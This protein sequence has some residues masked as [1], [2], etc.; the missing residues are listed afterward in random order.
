M[1]LISKKSFVKNILPWLMCSLA[2]VFYCYEY[3]QR[4]STSVL[5]T[6]IME[7]YQINIQ[8]FG[9]L[10]ASYYWAYTPMQVLVGTLMD[11][12]GVRRLMTMAIF[13]CA[14]GAFFFG[15]HDS[16]AIAMLSRFT[17]GFG[18]AFA[19]VGVLKLASDWLPYRY[20]SL[21]SGITTML[22]MLGA[23]SGEIL[24]EDLIQKIG[25]RPT[26]LSSALFAALLTVCAWFIIKDHPR[27]TYKVKK[28]K[29]ASSFSLELR[30]LTQDISSVFMQKQ[31]L[32][33]AT[34]G[35]CLFM[36]TTLFA[37][38]WGVDY[39][40]NVKSV[41]IIQAATITSSIFVGWAIGA[42]IMGLL[43]ERIKS[44]RYL[45]MAGS[46]IA[47][48]LVS[49]ALYDHSISLNQ[50]RVLFFFVGFASSTQVLVFAVAHDLVN[51]KLIG[52]GVA[53]TNM[54][55][56]IGGLIQPIIG[57][58]LIWFTPLSY[59]ATVTTIH[60]P[61]SSYEKALLVLPI[62]FILSA[63][64]STCFLKE[65]YRAT[66]RKMKKSHASKPIISH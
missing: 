30:S 41:S 18:S 36:P 17:I 23:I 4:V 32:I 3:F 52:T 44:R 6:E 45:M 13:L 51:P 5:Q 1:S 31:F 39:L 43:T 63:I 16:I 38:Q 27:S 56:N 28:K 2:A 66:D 24:L 61:Q 19:F 49:I 9:L 62:C 22:G 29:G 42:P 26:L 50:M 7:L 59:K 8:T 40:V 34:L 14:L 47:T 48:L 60:Y 35:A 10:S 12:F 25:L 57:F 64:I 58:M 33:N 37:E 55:I 46:F 20:F 53:L 11:H 54:I 15:L 21:F 65:S